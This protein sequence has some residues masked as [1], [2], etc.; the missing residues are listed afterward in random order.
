M[1]DIRASFELITLASLV[2]SGSQSSDYF[3]DEDPAFLDALDAIVLP[4]DAPVNNESESDDPEPP[5][6]GQPSAKRRR[7]EEPDPVDEGIYGA[8]GFGE[9]GNYMNRKRAKLQIQNSEI[10][11]TAETLIFKGISVYVS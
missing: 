10:T 4:G 9:F 5:P 3:E 1:Y 11:T 8:I 6:P 2:E 7:N